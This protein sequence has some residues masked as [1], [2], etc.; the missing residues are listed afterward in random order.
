MAENDEI[1]TPQKRVG[2]NR[3]VRAVIYS[4]EGFGSALKH[5]SAFRFEVFLA[6]IMLP[7]AV[8]LP[9]GL[10]GKALMIGSVLLVLITE[11][12]NS[13]IEWVV[14]YVSLDSHPFAKRS[15][16][17]AS[18]AVFI[19]LLNVITIWALVLAENWDAVSEVFLP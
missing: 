12:L 8:L 5:E 4:A 3:L 18:A 6:A 17:M 19:S 2:L 11:L 15:K 1:P 13:A 10:L 9:V 14:D 16:D 7:A